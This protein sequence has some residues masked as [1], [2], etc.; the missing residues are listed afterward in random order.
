MA[1]TTL[2]KGSSGD[3]VKALQYIAGVKADGKFGVNTEE[4]VKKLQKRYGLEADGKAGQ[5]T[6]EAIAKHA[7]YLKFGS[8]GPY[9]YALESIL[10]T[11]KLDGVFTQN[12]I[13]SVKTYQASKNMGADGIVG[14]KTWTALFGLDQDDGGSSGSGESTN[15]DPKQ[16]TNFKQYDSRW[17]SCIYTRNNTYNKKQ[18]I[19]NSGCGPTSMA[20]IV[21]FWFD[22]K[23]TPKEMAALSV[24]NG[25]RTKND[26]T[27]WAF[28]EFVSKKYPF[29]KFI[30]TKSFV[31]MQ[32]CLAAGALVVVS[33]K[34]SKWTKN[35]HFCVFWKD[36]GKYIYVNDPASASAARAKGTYSEVKSAAKQYFCFYK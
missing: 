3:L 14:I 27:D 17:G 25:Y 15:K 12:E 10:N 26:G 20:D 23:V 4:A 33:F 2:K 36:D 8:T 16:P 21:N 30:Q 22:K 19:K 13:E 1:F 32:N 7:P 35:G 29:S 18:T 5:K 34:K 9:V 11:M 28:Y 24:A 31:T 6:F